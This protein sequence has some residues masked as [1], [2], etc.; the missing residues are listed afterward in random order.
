MRLKAWLPHHAVRRV[1]NPP[2]DTITPTPVRRC[3]YANLRQPASMR[4]HQALANG[5]YATQA[6]QQCSAE[7]VQESPQLSK[8]AAVHGCDW[9]RM[10]GR[11]PGTRMV[12]QLACTCSSPCRGSCDVTQLSEN[13]VGAPDTAV[14]A[15]LADRERAGPHGALRMQGQELVKAG[16][17]KWRDQIQ[18]RW[19]SERGLAMA[20]TKAISHGRHEG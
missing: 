11:G 12:L 14:N 16:M 17:Q 6:H 2:V 10:R 18:E 8:A 15:L 19:L 9:M 13:R 5:N 20:Q 4:L 7:A 1:C 3:G